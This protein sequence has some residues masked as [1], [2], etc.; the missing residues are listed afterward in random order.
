VSGQVQSWHREKYGM[1]KVG[2]SELVFLQVIIDHSGNRID[3]YGCRIPIAVVY[4][5]LFLGSV[6]NLAV[7][8]V[9]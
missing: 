8:A 5:A 9:V 1:I 7:M 3:G 6:T 4:A 2:V